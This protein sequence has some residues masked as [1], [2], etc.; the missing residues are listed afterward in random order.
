MIE[1]FP[2]EKGSYALWMALEKATRVYVG[3]FG[4]VD[5]PHGDYIYLGSARG[6]GGLRARLRHH[7][8]ISYRPHWHIDFLRSVVIVR[9]VYYTVSEQPLECEWSQILARVS[10]AEIPVPGFGASDCNNG[11]AAHLVGFPEGINPE[12]F[13]STLKVSDEK[14]SFVRLYEAG[15]PE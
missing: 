7:L 3:R 8:R 10:G 12:A 13:F 14:L 11:C 9:G 5:F 4:M 6:S 15:I 1:R 2:V